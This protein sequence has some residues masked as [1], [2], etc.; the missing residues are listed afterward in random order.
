MKFNPYGGPKPLISLYQWSYGGYLGPYLVIYEDGC[1]IKAVYEGHEEIFSRPKIKAT[2]ISADE[3]NLIKGK[4]SELIDK[5]ER[6]TKKI[7]DLSQGVTDQPTVDIM[8]NISTVKHIR[9]KGC[10]IKNENISYNSDRN[11]ENEYDIEYPKQEKIP[12]ALKESLSFIS[13][14]KFSDFKDYIPYYFKFSLEEKNSENETVDWPEEFPELDNLPTEK[15]SGNFAFYM[16][17]KYYKKVLEFYLN[18]QQK[19][20]VYK[21]RERE[22]YYYPRLIFPHEELFHYPWR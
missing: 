18:N 10:H 3:L 13:E 14:Y 5:N 9:I 15:Y 11:E 4:L 7:Y 17:G 16:D 6:K 19:N 12:N 8:C 21:G 22:L 2:I 20:V 1:V